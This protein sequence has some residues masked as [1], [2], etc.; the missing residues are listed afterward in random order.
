[1]SNVP[2]AKQRLFKH[3]SVAKLQPQERNHCWTHR[4][5]FSSCGIKGEEAISSC[6]NIFHTYQFAEM[7]IGI[8][9]MKLKITVAQSG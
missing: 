6:Q 7:N 4:F 9:V 5:L 8:L 3:D 2:V 1:M